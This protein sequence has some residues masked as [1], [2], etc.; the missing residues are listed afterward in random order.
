MAY[1]LWYWPT[2]PGRGEF[3]RLALEA[4]GIDYRDR[5]REEGAAA[6]V[7]DL[8]ER[9]ARAPFAPPYLALEGLVIA[10]VANI[11]MFLGERHGL[12]PSSMADRLWLNEVQLTISDL[13]AEVHNVHHPVGV[14]AYY[15]E[16]KPEAA[17]AAAPFREERLPKFLHWFEKAVT[18]HPGDWLIDGRWTYGDTSLFQLVEGL[19]YMFPKRMAT[20]EPDYPGVIRV[21]D[22][23]A[24]LP[25]VR[26]YRN[27]DRAIPFN[28]D[29]I[30]R[31]YPE[32]DAA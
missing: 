22:M 32:L 29:G 17:R 7:A 16:Q 25:G 20:L 23:V 13:V 10:Q 11:L 15:D 21:H 5:A 27:S 24:G 26:A 9:T 30:F 8:E 14:G 12:G 6:L 18:C 31:H 4:A 2:I 3:V 19:R 1:D 28:E